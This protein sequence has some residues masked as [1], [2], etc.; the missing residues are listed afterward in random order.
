MSP[1]TSNSGYPNESISKLKDSHMSEENITLQKN[2]KKANNKNFEEKFISICAWCEKVQDESG[3]WI[4]ISSYIKRRYANFTHGY[5]P[6]CFA[7][8]LGELE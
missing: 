8:T 4:Q 2:V 7:R 1:N 6:D 3:S 5:C